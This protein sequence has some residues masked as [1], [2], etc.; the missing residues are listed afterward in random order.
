[1]KRVFLVIHGAVQGVGYRY[2]VKTR[3]NKY[4][5]NGFVRNVEDGSVEVL[6]ESEDENAMQKFIKEINVDTKNGP[7]V[8]KIEMNEEK[9]NKFSKSTFTDFSV[10]EYRA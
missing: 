7:Q 3:A 8:F 1:M 5:I 10:H 6:A 2:F 9:L 4:A